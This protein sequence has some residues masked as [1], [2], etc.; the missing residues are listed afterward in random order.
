MQLLNFLRE[1]MLEEFEA[2]VQQRDLE[3]K[4]AQLDRLVEDA[5]IRSSGEARVSSRIP[6]DVAI[7][8]ASLPTKKAEI[9]RLQGQIAELESETG[10][11]IE[12]VDS[13]YKFIEETEASVRSVL[14]AFTKV[15]PCTR[16][17]TPQALQTTSK[18]SI[19][20]LQDTI[21]ELTSADK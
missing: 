21:F 15:S 7:R 14:A 6:P 20:Q 10:V 5:R 2:I 11:L 9:A 18:I 1:S 3:T 13:N 4:L 17:L 19:K 8:A 12:K 16:L